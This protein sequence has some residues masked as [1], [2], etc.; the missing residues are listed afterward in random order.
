MTRDGSKQ[1]EALRELLTVDVAE[2][3]GWPRCG[4]DCGVIG[5]LLV[6]G[7]EKIKLRYFDGSWL[8][9]NGGLIKESLKSA[10]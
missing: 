4:L 2:I 6:G 9:C 5:R 1:A 10:R 8:K 7:G 3:R